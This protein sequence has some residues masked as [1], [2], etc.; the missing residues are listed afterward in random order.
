MFLRKICFL[1]FL[2]SSMQ[3]HGMALKKIVSGLGK[4]LV[5]D[6]LRLGLFL[7]QFES[8]H[9]PESIGKAEFALIFL[10][11]GPEKSYPELERILP[12]MI[13]VEKEAYENGSM[14][15]YHGAGHLVGIFLTLHKMLQEEKGT[16]VEK[17][18][19]LRIPGS[20]KHLDRISMECY[21]AQF[22]R[23]KRIDMMFGNEL[24]SVAYSPLASSPGPVTYALSNLDGFRQKSILVKLLNHYGY[25][26]DQYEIDKYLNWRPK[27]GIYLQ[28]LMPNE[29][30][31]ECLYNA[32]TGGAPIGL[33]II[34]SD[35]QK[36]DARLQRKGRRFGFSPWFGYKKS[37]GEELSNI[38]SD[39][40]GQ[41]RILLR[42]L[43]DDPNSG[44]K[45]FRYNLYSPEDAAREVVACREILK[46]AK[47]QTNLHRG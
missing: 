5:A 29:L 22:L 7:K 19:F 44:I 27:T 1:L 15:L 8:F 6:K 35:V 34:D 11:N 16:K 20:R 23:D 37:I 45:I 40:E 28:I 43:F 46:Q 39:F 2:V 41:A 31:N 38:E 26:L 3:I 14:V 12:S 24:L 13:S 47:K 21:K 9:E 32:A 33:P 10:R 4:C 25:N 36:E 42:S 18:E 30:V 17:F